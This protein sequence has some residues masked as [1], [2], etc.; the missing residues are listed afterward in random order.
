MMNEQTPITP[1]QVADSIRCLEHLADNIGDH[2]VVL[3][4]RA[5]GYAAP[6]T[7]AGPM[8]RRAVETICALSGSALPEGTCELSWR[9]AGKIF[10]VNEHGEG[11]WFWSVCCEL[12]ML[13]QGYA[14]TLADAIRAAGESEADHADAQ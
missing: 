7:G 13:A 1:E 6:I 10:G 3:P 5:G 14:E 12:D 8:L 9:K 4:N 2:P 11:R